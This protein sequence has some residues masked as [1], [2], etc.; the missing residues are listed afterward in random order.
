M[1][2]RGEINLAMAKN[3]VMNRAANGQYYTPQQVKSEG[4]HESMIEWKGIS[5]T[6]K[7]LISF[8]G[9]RRNYDRNAYI[10][11]CE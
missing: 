3:Y 1:K 10:P 11:V 9:W 7:N 5:K 2:N 8:K 6:I 4:L